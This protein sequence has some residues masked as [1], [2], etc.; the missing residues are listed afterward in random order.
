MSTVSE[1]VKTRNRQNP[2]RSPATQFDSNR[3]VTRKDYPPDGRCQLCGSMPKKEG[4]LILDCEPEKRGSVTTENRRGWLCYHCIHLIRIVQT[5]GL[6]KLVPYL[7]PEVW[8]GGTP[9]QELER[10]YLAR[11]MRD[12]L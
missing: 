9:R 5:I 6:K 1:R 11:H 10:E 12:N 8:Q 2:E 3:G 7:I 4:S